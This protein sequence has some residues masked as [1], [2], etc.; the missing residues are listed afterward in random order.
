[1]DEKSKMDHHFTQEELDQMERDLDRMSPE[2]EPCTEE[3]TQRTSSRYDRRRRWWEQG[4]WER[5][6]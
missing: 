5:S 6:L 3:P 1:V 2:V 4:K